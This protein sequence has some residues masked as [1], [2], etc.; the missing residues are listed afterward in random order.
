[1]YSQ[2]DVHLLVLCYMPCVQWG[3]GGEGKELQ[4]GTFRESR[5]AEEQQNLKMHV[6]KALIKFLLLNTGHSYV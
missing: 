1:M 4:I 5:T 3:E 2:H 6:A